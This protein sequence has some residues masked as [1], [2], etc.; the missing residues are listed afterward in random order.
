MGRLPGWKGQRAF[1][2]ERPEALSRRGGSRKAT[3]ESGLGNED[4]RGLLKF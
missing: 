1:P 4:S 2:L 3:E